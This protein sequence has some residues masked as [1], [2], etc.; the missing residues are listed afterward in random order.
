MKPS[1][2]RKAR[3]HAMQ[4]LYQVLYT[5]DEAE[6]VI[7]QHLS[8]INTN[9]VD[10]EYFKDLLMGAVNSSSL[11]DA[12][13]V[14]FLERDIDT[15]TPVELSILRLATFELKEKP[16]V[17]YQVIINEALELTKKFGTSEGYRFVNGV[18]DKTARVLRT[19]E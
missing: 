10:V 7:A 11:L 18:L 19:V 14:E 2:R 5:G 8:E 16:D 13:F 6:T 15:V 17:P 3:K 12:C 9:K 1:A 4:G